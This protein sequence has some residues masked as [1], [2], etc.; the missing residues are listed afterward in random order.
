MMVSK[1]GGG[2]LQLN[3]LYRNENE[4]NTQRNFARNSHLLKVPTEGLIYL[5]NKVSQS[6]KPT[7]LQIFKDENYKFTKAIL[8]WQ[9]IKCI[10]S[11]AFSYFHIAYT[12][13]VF[14]DFHVLEYPV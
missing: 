5:S 10:A 7:L 12:S 6:R 3:T 2:N 11:T 9:I 8:S 14:K 13:V 1:E 4:M